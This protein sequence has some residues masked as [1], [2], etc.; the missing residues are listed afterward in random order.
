VAP[1]PSYVQRQKKNFRRELQTD[2]RRGE[3]ILNL[4]SETGFLVD[5][6]SSHRP[7]SKITKTKNKKKRR[8]GI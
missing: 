3:E 5:P 8:T 4:D 2:K 7:P 1:G 6:L